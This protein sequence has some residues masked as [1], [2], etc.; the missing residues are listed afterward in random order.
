[1]ASIRKRGE[2]F[3]ARV[4]VRGASPATRTFTNRKDAQQWAKQAEAA[5]LRGAWIDRSEAEQT[6][7]R[8]A[9][10]RYEREIT[11]TKKGAVQERNVIAQITGHAALAARSLAS[12]KAAD[13]AKLRDELTAKGCAPATIAR[14]LA[15]LSHLFTISIKEWGMTCLTNPVLLIRKPAVRNARTRRLSV[16][17]E[18]YL[19]AACDRHKGGWL[20]PVVELALAT[21]MRRGEIAGLLWPWVDLSKRTITLPDTKNGT[22]RTVPCQRRREFRVNWPVW[23]P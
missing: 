23:N 12:I 10:A 18:R 4:R 13:I 1:M 15:V 2:K 22:A 3:Q 8:D 21:C 17:E 20:R 7:L 11:S 16:V 19:L 14:R 6:S 5:M 9:L